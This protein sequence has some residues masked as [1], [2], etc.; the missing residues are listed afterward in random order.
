M[1][2]HRRRAE[3]NREI[4]LSVYFFVPFRIYM[5]RKWYLERGL[6]YLLTMI[7]YV[8]TGLLIFF[9]GMHLAERGLVRGSGER[10]QHILH[11][12]T[13]N[14]PSAVMTGTIVTAIVQSSSAVSVIVIGF[15]NGGVM[16]LY[17]GMGVILGANIGTTMTMHI[18]T[19]QAESLEWW[20]IGLGLLAIVAGW[21]NHKQVVVYGGIVTVGFGLIFVGLSLL[22]EGVAPLQNEPFVIEWLMRFG[23]QPMLAILV[24]AGLTGIIQS[25]SAVSGIVL[26]IIRQGMITTTGAIGVILGANVGTCVTALLAGVNT[27]QIA[28]R[29]AYFHLL[30][31]LFGVVLFIPILR[32]FSQFV[33]TLSPDPGRQIALAHTIFNLTSVILITPLLKPLANFFTPRE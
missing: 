26:T 24:G 30:F 29:L 20:L 33:M 9:F 22:Q 18:L 1:I 31:N 23:N 8:V 21:V 19:F 13:G 15:V 7:L 32:I 12:F 27:N 6:I 11:T 3:I 2:S 16:S 4:F 17:Q 28:R 5:K 25:S 14:L 10:L